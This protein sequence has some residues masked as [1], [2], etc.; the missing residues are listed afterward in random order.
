MVNNQPLW[1]RQPP[2]HQAIVSLFT[3]QFGLIH[4]NIHHGVST[5]HLI[6]HA[7]ILTSLLQIYPNSSNQRGLREDISMLVSLQNQHIAQ[8]IKVESQHSPKRRK[9]NMDSA[10]N[11]ANRTTQSTGLGT[12]AD[13]EGDKALRHVFSAN[14]AIWQDGTGHGVADVYAAAPP[15]SPVA[16]LTQ[17][18]QS[19]HELA[20]EATVK[21]SA[22]QPWINPMTS[23]NA[24]PTTP[25]RIRTAKRRNTSSSTSPSRGR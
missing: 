13:N 1:S 15:P 14:A 23:N 4:Q 9:S 21:A 8:W 10:A 6:E 18:C 24:A 5:H 12:R 20:T 7:S 25:K 17:H 3:P 2:P 22:S 11:V 16:R 19:T